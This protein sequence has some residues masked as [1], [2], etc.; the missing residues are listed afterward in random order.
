MNPTAIL[1]S[2]LAD[3]QR[4]VKIL[5]SPSF[6][7]QIAD[8]IGQ[9]FESSIRMLPGRIHSTINAVTNT[10]LLNALHLIVRSLDTTPGA[11]AHVRAHRLLTAGT[12]AIAGALG[13][14][15]LFAELPFSTALMLRAI[16]DIARSEGHDL[17]QP[18]VQLACLEVFALGG[19]TERDNAVDSSYWVARAALAKTFAEAATWIAER[20]V[21]TTSAPA[22]VRYVG[23]IALRLSP[24]FAAQLAVRAV[25]VIS[26]ATAATVNVM[27]M[28]HFQSMARGHFIVRRLEATYGQTVV[29]SA[30]RA[31]SDNPKS[32]T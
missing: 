2:D 11:R 1:P 4:A 25:P 28:S 8:L 12:G 32:K 21:A 5:E 29:S 24:A 7:M 19:V 14:W 6:A 9:P 20:G 10:A 16:A 26:A 15:T 13:P 30:Y 22:V 27:F 18:E 3:L 31:L 17:A 23:A